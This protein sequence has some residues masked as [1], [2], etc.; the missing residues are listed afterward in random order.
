MAMLGGDPGTGCG[1]GRTLNHFMLHGIVQ[2]AQFDQMEPLRTLEGR[3]GE[4]IRSL[5]FSLDIA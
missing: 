3:F 1:F 2:C 4:D 5:I